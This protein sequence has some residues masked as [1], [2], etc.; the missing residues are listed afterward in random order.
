MDAVRPSWMATMAGSCSRVVVCSHFTSYITVSLLH[1]SQHWTFPVRLVVA[2][3]SG[4]LLISNI[5]LSCERASLVIPL[6]WL[7]NY[8]I[9]QSLSSSTHS[10]GTTCVMSMKQLLTIVNRRATIANHLRAATSRRATLCGTTSTPSSIHQS[11]RRSPRLAMDRYQPR[12]CDTRVITCQLLY[13]YAS[14][15]FTFCSQS[16]TQHLATYQLSALRQWPRP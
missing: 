5:L 9:Q 13:S 6:I 8:I 15:S 14:K 3:M 16:A 2:L 11:I 7:I 12:L 1:T 4:F 10:T